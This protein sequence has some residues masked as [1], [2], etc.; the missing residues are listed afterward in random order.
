[1]EEEA[2]EAPQA[3]AQEDAPAVQVIELA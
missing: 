3:Q 1:V 2:H